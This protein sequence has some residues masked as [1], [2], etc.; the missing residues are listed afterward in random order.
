MGPSNTVILCGGIFT[1][2]SA[3]TSLTRL[4]IALST[5]AQYAESRLYATLGQPNSLSDFGWH[6]QKPAVSC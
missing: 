3:G 1:T 6:S 5:N 2:S 4:S